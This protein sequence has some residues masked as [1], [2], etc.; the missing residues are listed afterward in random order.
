LTIGD[1]KEAPEDPEGRARWPGIYFLI[2][3]HKSLAGG[4]ADSAGF[5]VYCK[6]GL[7]HWSV[8]APGTNRRIMGVSA[9]LAT[10]LDDMEGQYRSGAASVSIL[11]KER[12]AKFQEGVNKA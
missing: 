3:M 4:F 7:Y 8:K 12:E 9:S 1:R 11:K 5:S 2:A 10:L 6:G